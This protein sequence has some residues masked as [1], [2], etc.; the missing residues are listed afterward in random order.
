MI[1]RS[2]PF[3]F[4]ISV[5]LTNTIVHETA[6]PLSYPQTFTFSNIL[7]TSSLDKS[8][9]YCTFSNGCSYTIQYPRIV[10]LHNYDN[11]CDGVS[12]EYAIKQTIYTLH[13]YTFCKH[14]EQSNPNH[15]ISDKNSPTITFSPSQNFKGLESFLA[16]PSLQNYCI[17]I[18]TISAFYLPQMTHQQ[19]TLFSYDCTVIILCM[20]GRKQNG[21]NESHTQPVTLIESVMPCQCILTM[22]IRG[23][24]NYKI[25]KKTHPFISLYQAHKHCYN[26]AILA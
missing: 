5:Q 8:L 4:P 11:P 19:F 1:W 23:N 22:S 20:R 16:K 12:L 17:D 26:T 13:D 3:R 25:R 24:W 6:S 9:L 14:I 2:L 15:I 18:C 7:G 10:H 21:T